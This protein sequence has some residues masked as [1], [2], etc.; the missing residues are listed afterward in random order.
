ME[1]LFATDVLS[2]RER[3]ERTLARQ[4]VDRVCLHEQLS[5]N[6]RV[7]ADWT[8][9]PVVGFNYGLQE[10]GLAIQRSLDTCFPPGFAHR[11]LYPVV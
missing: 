3:L 4:P 10:I 1:R 11:H 8:G 7:I 2:K 9:R 6:P 5:Y